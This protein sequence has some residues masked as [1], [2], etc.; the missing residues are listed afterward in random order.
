MQAILA[1]IA[2]SEGWEKVQG[3]AVLSTGKK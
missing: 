2:K 1:K 3:Y